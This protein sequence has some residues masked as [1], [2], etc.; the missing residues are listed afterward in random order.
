MRRRYKVAAEWQGLRIVKIMCGRDRGL[1]VLRIEG[2]YS[3]DG[4]IKI[5]GSKNGVLPVM[6]ASLLHKGTTVLEHVPKIQ[7]VFC[8]LGILNALGADC[9]MEG[10]RLV[11]SAQ[12]IT[13]TEIP[14][15]L[16]GQMRSSVML[17]GPL[18]ARR[19]QVETSLPG[20]CRIG[21]R[22]VDLHIRGLAALGAEVEL[23]NGRIRAVCPKGEPSGAEIHLPYPSVGATEN[24]LMAAAGARGETVLTGAAREPE[25]EILCSFLRAMGVTVQGAGTSVIR[26]SGTSG[27]QD[28][29]FCLPG[30]RIVAGTYLGTVLCAGGQVLLEQAPAEHMKRTMENARQMGAQIEALEQGI[31]VSMR[32]R[33]RPVRIETGPYPEFPTDMQ[34]VMMAAAALADGT[35][36][37][38]ENV[39]ENRFCVAKEL[40]KLGAHIIIEDKIAA[41]EGVD[42]LKGACVEAEDLRGGAAL[43]AACLA[44]EGISFL[45]G[46]E[47]ISRGYEDISR[48]LAGA[49]AH[50]TLIR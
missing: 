14:E 45:G 10:D 24:I 6:A 9:R 16:A 28:T 39:F 18:L 4:T 17:L 31:W 41:V 37:I 27:F 47:H 21:K 23:E 44:A 48:D 33:P 29:R 26:V 36:H 30:D 5:Q 34:S 40:Q 19:G 50:I 15:T 42:V 43:A 12:S 1:S 32:G 7:D 11:I 46:Y 35:S 3:L 20:G 49:G 25:I 8:M 2:S 22:P 13:G 38:R